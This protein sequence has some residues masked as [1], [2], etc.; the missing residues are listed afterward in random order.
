MRLNAEHRLVDKLTAAKRETVADLFAM[1]DKRKRAI[2]RARNWNKLAWQM[3]RAVDGMAVEY[4][5]ELTKR[6]AIN[7]YYDEGH[8]ERPDQIAKVQDQA[9]AANE[10]A[11]T[12]SGELATAR[13]SI[14]AMESRI[15]EM[16]ERMMDMTGRALRAETALAATTARIN[17][18]PPAVARVTFERA[19]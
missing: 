9:F 18:W 8:R 2:I 3:T 11:D 7:T 15:D 16:A 14:G 10:R 6:K 19:A 5:A 12:L 17:G 13:A 4:A 1:R